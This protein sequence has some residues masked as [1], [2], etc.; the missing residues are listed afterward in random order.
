MPTDRKP[1]CALSDDQIGDF[2]LPYH[3]DISR[4]NVFASRAA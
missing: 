2:K 3:L 1:Q 4:R